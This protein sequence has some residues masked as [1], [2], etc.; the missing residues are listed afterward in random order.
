MKIPR[1]A[2]AALFTMLSCDV[3]LPSQ[4]FEWI[5]F[6]VAIKSKA[7]P[8]ALDPE[9]VREDE[10]DALQAQ[11]GLL[12]EWE[13]IEMS[14]ASRDDE[15]ELEQA[16]MGL[17]QTEE[18]EFEPMDVRTTD[19]GA[20]TYTG[21]AIK[22]NLQFSQ[23]EGFESSFV[24]KEIVTNGIHGICSIESTA[25]ILYAPDTGYSGTDKCGYRFCKVDNG[26]SCE[27]AT[28]SITVTKQAEEVA[29]NDAPRPVSGSDDAPLLEAQK[30]MLEYFEPTQVDPEV[31][32]TNEVWDEVNQGILEWEEPPV[33]VLEQNDA[34]DSSGW[35][36]VDY[37]SD[38]QESEVLITIELLTD[39]YGEEVRWNL[40][41]VHNDSDA[42]DTMKIS[43][44]PY[45][46]HSFDQVDL[47][48]PSPSLYSFNIYD[49][50]GDG[51]GGKGYY[52]IFLNGK[53]ILHVSHYGKGNTHSINVGFDPTP[54]MTQR[55]IEY[56]HAHNKRRRK[57]HEMHGVSYVPLTWSPRLKE[58]SRRW[59]ME[60]LDA[61]DSDGI[62]HE[63]GV[64]E[65]ENLAENKGPVEHGNR[66]GQLYPPENIVRRWVDREIGWA[67][68]D[69]AHLTQSL[70]RASRY[71]GCGEAEKDY[72]G[73]K[74]RVQVCRYI[75]AGN[76]DMKMFNSTE[77]EN[78]LVPMLKETSSCEPSCP[79][80]GCYFGTTEKE[81]EDSFTR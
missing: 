20:T 81:Q 33:V 27:F 43:S 12:G 77:G 80:E 22:V 10:G 24:V 54:A 46:R 11:L 40:T 37:I 15:G 57:W 58:E 3:A 72:R 61:C 36:E 53:E 17:S 13:H 38:C 35:Q 59:A 66:M 73:G 31:L 4:S 67:Y 44:R 65:G 16:P 69:N 63:P 18:A 62:D 47:C 41:R 28:L 14:P 45:G 56:L 68:P 60:L 75:K 71:L 25:A 74:C 5:P 30:P 55:D 34:K 32:L 6:P 76:C 49:D 51:L 21:Q 2:F 1:L 23:R 79:P 78:W 26:L 70:W 50:Y 52:K 64:V 7:E 48:A 42:G 29:V 39:S 9:P 19:D 8:I